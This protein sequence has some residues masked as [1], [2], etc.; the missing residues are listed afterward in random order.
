MLVL[1]R[2]AQE[3]IVFPDLQTT[4]QIVSVKGGVVRLSF[5]APESV[6]I[7]REE[8]LAKLS[9][10]A[11]QRQAPGNSAEVRLREL[12]HALNNQL[13]SSTIGL[14]L[15][16]RQ[17]EMGRY[18]ELAGTLDRM[19]QEL[20][21]LRER[22]EKATADPAPPPRA[23][24]RRPKA[25]LVEDDRNECELLAG[26]L[27]LAGVEVG[28]AGDGT[29]A[30]DYLR[31]QEKPDVV[32]LDMLMPRC[33]GPTTVR[34]IRSDPTFAGLKIFGVTGVASDTFGLSEGPNGIDRWFRKPLNPEQLLQEMKRDLEKGA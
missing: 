21:R 10:E 19:E 5:D 31:H 22:S 23:G 8:V 20:K 27:R 18:E 28:V 13:N 29:D 16:R 32:L 6:R 12:G 1:S 25:L 11:L 14:A 34:E 33:D 3:K 7:Y 30:L 4:I 17:L 24:T 9:P 2:S 26:F 15:L